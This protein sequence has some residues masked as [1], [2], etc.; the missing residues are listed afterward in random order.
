MRP[1]TLLV[2]AKPPRIGLS[3]TRLAK[4]LGKAGARRVAGFTLA[5]T[6]AATR[7]SGCAVTICLSP[8]AEVRRQGKHPLFGKL[9]LRPQGPGG[10]TERLGRGFREAPPGPVLFIGTDAPDISAA[11][12]RQAVRALRRNDA[13]F[14]P[15]RDGGFWLF[16]LHK[17]PQTRAP[18]DA[19]RW[20]GPH[21]ME[22]V[23]SRLPPRS[24]IGLL[25]QLIDIDE[26]ADWKEWTRL[27][28]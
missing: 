20:S 25:D 9:H 12:L 26:V 21:A 6:L 15:A 11:R 23:W 2:F 3:K 27:K 16:G 13:V 19:V 14:G 17:G 8:D 18:F 5:R 28:R 24:R 1:A 10:L 7:A 22:D 4:G